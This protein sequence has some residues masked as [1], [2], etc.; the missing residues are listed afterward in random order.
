MNTLHPAAFWEDNDDP[1]SER[2]AE[3]LERQRSGEWSD[4]DRTEFDLWL[5]E[6]YRHRAAYLRVKG[7]VAYAEHLAAVH[8]FK[9]DFPSGEAAPRKRRF[10][11]SWIVFPLLAAASIAL[12]AAFGLPYVAAVMQPP[13]RTYSTDVGGQAL[14]K[15]ADRTQIELN[16]DTLVRYRMTSRERTVWLERGEAWFH[17]AHDASNPFTVIVG[18][19]RVTD[20]GT[21]FFVR[22]SAEGMEVALLKGRASL[23]TEGAQTAMLKPGD[24]AIATRISMSMTRRSPQ[25][26][27]DELAWRRGVLVFRSARLADAVREVNRYNAVKL[28]IADPS[29]ADLRF[30]GEIPSDS[31]EGFL[32]MAQ[33]MMKLH[34]D[35]EGRDI[36][37]SRGS[38]EK[39]KRSVR[40]HGRVS[41]P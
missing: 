27:A 5:A 31:Y 16:T 12:F 1:V 36:L 29:I 3:F 2:A 4:G 34:A 24:D 18:K 17:V 25:E 39:A 15:F 38:P 13:D 7:I 32:R 9:V 23:S 40:E 30:T 37:L 19:H 33:S 10:A 22:R 11:K 21:E 20:L 28:V 41:A 26:L 14:L 6:S 35:R 8:A